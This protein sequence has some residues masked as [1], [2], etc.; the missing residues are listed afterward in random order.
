M[1]SP[2]TVAASLLAAGQPAPAD[3]SIV[4][5]VTLHPL[6]QETYSCTEHWAGQ[7][8]YLGDA[9]G[10]DC[11]IARMIDTPDGGSFSALYRGDGLSNEDWFGHGEPVLA[12]I[13]G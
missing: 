4:D 10:T 8:G 1:L 7:L 12:P 3:Q 5:Q 13:N 6:Y 9:L 2:L 11:L